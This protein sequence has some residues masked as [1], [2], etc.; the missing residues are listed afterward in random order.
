MLDYECIL[1][2]LRLLVKLIVFMNIVKFV[3]EILVAATREAKI[4]IKT[5]INR[6]S[7]SDWRTMGGRYWGIKFTL[8]SSY[9]L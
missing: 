7:K 4:E 3:Q 1:L 5:R 9:H 2:P 6:P 8:L